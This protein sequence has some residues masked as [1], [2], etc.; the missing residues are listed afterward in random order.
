M[1]KS[2]LKYLESRFRSLGEI[3]IKI[4]NIL[5]IF[6]IVII[7]YKFSTDYILLKNKNNI[8][9]NNIDINKFIDNLDIIEKNCESTFITK[10]YNDDNYYIFKTICKGDNFCKSVYVPLSDCLK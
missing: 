9:I 5:I 7:I 10:Q 3:N 4:A 1:N 8:I 2:E 6:L